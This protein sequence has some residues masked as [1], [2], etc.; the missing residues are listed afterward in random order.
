MIRGLPTRLGVLTTAL[1]LAGRGPASAS[2][3][4]SMDTET[5][6]RL[7]AVIV[8]G[9]LQSAAVALDKRGEILTWVTIRVEE[10]LKGAEGGPEVAVG[11]PGGVWEPA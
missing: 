11:V 2:T 8:R 4:T 5:L 6:V 3:V 1:V 9:G 7:S 10:S